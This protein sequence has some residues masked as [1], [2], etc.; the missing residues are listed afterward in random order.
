MQ[1]LLSFT[2]ETDVC[3][4]VMYDT[5]LPPFTSGGSYVE[6]NEACIEPMQVSNDSTNWLMQVID[7]DV[8]DALD[9]N[10]TK[11]EESRS[12]PKWLVHTL[13]DSKLDALL[14]SRTHHSSQRSSYASYCYALVVSSMCDEEELITFNEAQN[15][16]NLMDTMQDEYDAIVKNETWSL[17]GFSIGKKEIGTKLVYKLKHK[18]DGSVEHHQGFQLTLHVKC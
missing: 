11:I 7:A 18:P 6:P 16:E 1:S 2:K 10:R 4:Q 3:S 13:C 17:C 14:P 5:L 15:L 8:H 12:M 9:Y